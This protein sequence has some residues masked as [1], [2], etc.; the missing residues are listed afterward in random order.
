MFVAS[1][2]KPT[3]ES[4]RIGSQRARLYQLY[5][6]P[7]RAEVSNTHLNFLSLYFSIEIFTLSLLFYWNLYFLFTVINFLVTSLPSLYF[8][9]TF[10][11]NSLLSLYFSSDISTFSTI[12]YCIVI[13]T[14]S[15]LSYWNLY[16]LFTVTS[17]LAQHS[18]QRCSLHLLPPIIMRTQ[19][20]K[21]TATHGIPGKAAAYT[22][23]LVFPPM[24]LHT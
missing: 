1:L 21:A 14:F 5:V 3:A 20:F 24:K 10:L 23:F 6:R 15:L 9:F 17:M 8:L 16:F 18:T 2:T 7:A 13:S 12:L 19:D 4:K 11:L 22:C